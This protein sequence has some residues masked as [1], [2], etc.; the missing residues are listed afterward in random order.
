MP[1]TLERQRKRAEIA[2]TNLEDIVGIDILQHERS[3]IEI[4]HC[5]ATKEM[6]VRG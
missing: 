4:R 3:V 1:E 2:C 5:T 6:V